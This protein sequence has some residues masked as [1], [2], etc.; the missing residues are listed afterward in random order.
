MLKL[1]RQRESRW[2]EL[3]G[4]GVRIKVKPL[5]TA[6]MEAFRSEAIKRNRVVEM[7]VSVNGTSCAE[8]G[9]EQ[10]WIVLQALDHHPEASWHHLPRRR[11]PHDCRCWC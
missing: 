10:G 2:I 3:D 1:T 9:W 8:G 6:I 5:T 7:C 4:L 11:Q